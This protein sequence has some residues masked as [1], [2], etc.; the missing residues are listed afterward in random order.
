MEWKKGTAVGDDV[1]EK[2]EAKYNIILP[3]EYRNTVRMHNYAYPVPNIFDSEVSKEH[4]FNRLLSF[5]ENDVENIF[6][7]IPFLGESNGSLF[8]FGFDPFGNILCLEKEKVVLWMHDTD[9]VEFVSNSFGEFLK[10]L[11]SI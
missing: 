9:K 7:F 10:G 6:V 4:V 3:T 2:V 1:I 5:D 11:Y 8:P